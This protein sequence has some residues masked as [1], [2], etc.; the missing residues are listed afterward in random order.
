MARVERGEIPL[1]SITMDLGDALIRT[2]LALH[3]GTPNLTP[4]PRPMVAI[5]YVMHWLRTPKVE[6]NVPR[7]AYQALDPE[8]RNMLRC[9]VVEELPTDSRESYVEFQY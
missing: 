5:G 7:A 2:P 6:L 9:K 4:D 1:D 3:R 8:L